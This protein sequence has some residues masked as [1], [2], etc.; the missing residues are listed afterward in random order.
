[1]TDIIDSVQLSDPGS[2]LIDLFEITVPTG[3][4]YFYPGLEN[5]I[6]PVYFP[7][8][9]GTTLNAYTAIPIE[10]SGIEIGADGAQARPTLN[11]A[12]IVG[13]ASSG[14]NDTT[15]GIE[16]ESL[17]SLTNEFFIGRK[18]TRRRTL[19]EHLL[20][21]GDPAVIPQEFPIATYVIDRISEENSIMVSFEL[22]S[23]LDVEGIKV[24]NRVI[25]GKYC[26]FQYQGYYS[27]PSRGGCPWKTTS[28]YEASSA[29]DGPG[30]VHEVFFDEFDR[31]CVSSAI[32]MAAF[33]SPAS[34]DTLVNDGTN[35]WRC[36]VDGT[37]VAPVINNSA[38][39]ILVEYTAYASGS[40]YS[41]TANPVYDV[42]YSAGALWTPKRFVP[43]NN[44]PFSGSS[45]WKRVD[46]CGKTVNSCKL[47]FQ[48]SPIDATTSAQG[49][50]ASSL[51]NTEKALPFGGYPGT[52]KF[53]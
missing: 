36:N 13:A 18:L 30:N 6:D 12:N 42:V 37:T 25:I 8:V 3:T 15:I 11:V 53:R 51:T 22:A 41:Y 38:W 5:S 4:L 34:V 23:P 32:A 29:I 48:F 28:L 19:G 46:V 50:V 43:T 45:Y 52:A 33:S 14:G 44:A 20:N 1:M 7:S 2:A 16:L 9:D 27:S 40:T 26:S 17:G 47:R 35:K 21:F 49:G 24:P 39:Q 31:P 10:I